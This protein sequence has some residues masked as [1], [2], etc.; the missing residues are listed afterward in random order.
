MKIQKFFQTVG[1]DYQEVCARF[2]SDAR[3]VKFLQMFP[4]DDSMEKLTQAM[5]S[6][7]MDTA[8]RAVHTMKGVAL[9]LG[10][11]A[12]ATAAST[13]TEALRGDRAMPDPALYDAVRR[14]Y[15]TVRQALNQLEA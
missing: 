8:F 3:I 7:D 10:L 11:S 6:G 9:N 13:L 15:D 2:Q 4:A 12:L 5:Q 1:G 14:E